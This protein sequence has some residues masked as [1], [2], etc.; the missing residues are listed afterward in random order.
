[1]LE[2]YGS[3]AEDILVVIAPSIGPCC[4]EVGEEVAEVFLQVYNE[5]KDHKKNNTKKMPEKKYMIDL[6]TANKLILLNVGILPENIT[7]TDICTK[8]NHDFMFSHRATEGKKRGSLA[9]IM[10]LKP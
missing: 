5:K 2:A 1:M 8:C 9:A 4:F 3:Q 7:V 6:W 10:E